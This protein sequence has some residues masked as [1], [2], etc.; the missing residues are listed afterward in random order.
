MRGLVCGER[1]LAIPLRIRGIFAATVL[2]A[3]LGCAAR[4]AKFE[5]PELQVKASQVPPKID[6]KLDDACWKGP[7]APR[8]Y[9]FGEGYEDDQSTRF[10][11]AYDQQCLYLGIRCAHPWPGDIQPKVRKHDG[12]VTTDESIEIFIAHGTNTGSYVHFMLSAGNIRADQ[13]VSGKV[14]NRAWNS[15]WHSATQ[16]TLEGWNAEIAIPWETVAPP[17]RLGRISI[18]VVRNA[19][20]P[21]FDACAVL[22]GHERDTSSWLPASK[23]AAKPLKFRALHGLKGITVKTSTEGK[24][25]P[26]TEI[27]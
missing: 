9:V 24:S 17:G 2:F 20:I 11:V 10:H 6:G 12:P 3:V 7:S 14:V 15:P 21:E 19:L 26:T 4:G 16:K 27:P 22:M 23:E 5:L 8:V 18:N 1:T 25:L 13:Q